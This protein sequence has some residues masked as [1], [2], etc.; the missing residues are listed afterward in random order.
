MSLAINVDHVTDV[1]LADGWHPCDPMDYSQDVG[2]DGA[3]SSFDLDAYE[4][5]DV[6][7]SALLPGGREDLVPATGFTFYEDGQRICGP[8]TSIIAVRTR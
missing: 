6:D 3:V 2:D 5:L 1:L 7:D 8:I 4:Y